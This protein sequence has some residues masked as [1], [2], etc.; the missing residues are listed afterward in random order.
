MYKRK[1]LACAAELQTIINNLPLKAI[2][3]LPPDFLHK[4]DQLKVKIFEFRIGP[5]VTFNCVQ[6]LKIL[7]IQCQT[8]K[9]Y[10]RSFLS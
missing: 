4:I 5:K 10:L 6:K 1:L 7:M 3:R 8:T 2:L 9:K